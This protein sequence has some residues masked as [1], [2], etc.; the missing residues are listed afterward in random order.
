VLKHQKL[1]SC[2]ARRLET[3]S[4]FGIGLVEAHKGRKCFRDWWLHVS[5]IPHPLG[6]RVTHFPRCLLSTVVPSRV[7]FASH[8]RR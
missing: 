8:E 6:Y 3:D 1:A 2:R 4:V 7:M 5:H